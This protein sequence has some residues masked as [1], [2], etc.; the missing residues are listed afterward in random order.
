M[1]TVEKQTRRKRCEYCNE[2]AD[3][4]IDGLCGECDGQYMT[5]CYVCN[6]NVSRDEYCRHIFW[7]EDGDVGTGTYD[8]DWSNVKPWLFKFLDL[9]PSDLVRAIRAGIIAE[10][11]Y[12]QYSCS[13]LGGYAHIWASGVPMLYHSLDGYFDQRSFTKEARDGLQWL[14]CLYKG[15]AK[16]GNAQTVA[17]LD[18]WLLSRAR[19]E[20][21]MLFHA[22][23]AGGTEGAKP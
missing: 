8:T 20:T 7:T 17:W 9:I 3:D 12:L 4:V 16:K 2:L 13:L 5:R 11:F 6:C 18:E 10:R 23:P 19:H 1:S 21:L 15:D 22:A 14:L